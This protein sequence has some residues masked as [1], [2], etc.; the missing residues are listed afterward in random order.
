[1]RLPIRKFASLSRGCSATAICMTFAPD[2]VSAATFRAF[3]EW[4]VRRTLVTDP[5]WLFRR[6]SVA[7]NRAADSVPGWPQIRVAVEVHST[8][9]AMPEALPASFQDDVEAWRGVLAGDDLFADNAPSR[10]LRPASVQ[11]MVGTVYRFASGMVLQG[12]PAAELRRMADLFQP[13]HFKLGLRFQ[14]ARHD[15]EGSP[16]ITQ[17]TDVL[18]GAARH[19]AHIDAAQLQIAPARC[20]KDRMPPE[21]P[22]PD[23]PPAAGAV[24]RSR[25]HPDPG[26]SP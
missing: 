22:D 25:Q 15:G 16:G 2:R 13:A 3:R 10:P 21:R 26:E 8:K 1:M 18:L 7:W 6:I 12:V 19:W 24:R 23:Q 17:M 11:H 14:L 9:Y 5:V 20:E 4:L